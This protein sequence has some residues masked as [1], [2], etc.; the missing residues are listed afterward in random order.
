MKS[1]CWIIII[2]AFFI[3]FQQNPMYAILVMAAVVFGYIL[4]KSRRSD[5]K[6]GFFSFLKGSDSQENRY[7]DDVIT[8]MMLQQLFNGSNGLHEQEKVNNKKEIEIE[9]IKQEILELLDD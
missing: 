1:M 6:R 3:Y 7:L 8:I 5:S 2:I 9:K 4:V